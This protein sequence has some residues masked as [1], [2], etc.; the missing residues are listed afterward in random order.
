M[1]RAWDDKEVE[2]TRKDGV[3]GETTPFGMTDLG[4]VHV[5]SVKAIRTLVDRGHIGVVSAV[6]QKMVL[7]QAEVICRMVWAALE[8]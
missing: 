2:R 5:Q 3:S 8:P 1:E 7:Y 6:G 4:S